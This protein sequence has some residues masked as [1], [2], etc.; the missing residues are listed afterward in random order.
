MKHQFKITCDSKLTT[1][2]NIQSNIIS[3]YLMSAQGRSKLAQSM[4]AP[5]RRQLD[6]AG[7]ARKCF[8]VEPLPLPSGLIY[9]TG[10]PPIPDK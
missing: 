1:N 5:I 6:Y 10:A 2:K 4:I 8:S 3:R 7:I 9:Y